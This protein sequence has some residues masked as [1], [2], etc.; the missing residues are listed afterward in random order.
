[1]EL[2]STSGSFVPAGTTIFAGPGFAEVALPSGWAGWVCSA[3]G[4]LGAGGFCAGVGCCAAAAPA[5]VRET[6]KTR[7]SSYGDVARFIT[8]T[9][10]LL[11]PMRLLQSRMPPAGGDVNSRGQQARVSADLTGSGLPLTLDS[12]R[13]LSEAEESAVAERFGIEL[14]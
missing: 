7:K 13:S 10:S 2:C 4:A 5:R 8:P 3:C 6:K 12:P 11:T 9:D 1:M 14:A